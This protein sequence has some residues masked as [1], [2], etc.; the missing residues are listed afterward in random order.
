[1]MMQLYFHEF[2]LQLK[3]IFAI[4][5][6][7]RTVQP[8]LIVELKLKEISGFGEATAIKYYDQTTEKF[9]E[10]LLKIKAQIT[11]NK[12]V[13]PFEFYAQICSLT[14]NQFLRSALDCAYH[15]LY[16]KV[17]QIP[18]F[19]T[20]GFSNQAKA[21]SSYTIGVDDAAQMLNKI[22]QTPWPI[23]KIK[24]NTGFDIEILGFLKRHTSAEF[25]IDANT[26]FSYKHLSEVHDYLKDLSINIIEQPLPTNQNP[27]MLK[28]K[29]DFDFTFIADESFQSAED[30]EGCI[31]YF[32]C[33]NIKLLKCGGITSAFQIIE[34]VKQTPTKL[35]IGCMTQSSVAISAAA[36]LS[37]Q[38]NYLDLDGAMLLSNDPARGVK[39]LPKRLELDQSY[40]NAGLELLH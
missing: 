26:G 22:K 10:E 39:I 19:K 24:V 8:T 14:R 31:K 15:D 38:A 21:I 25:R 33:I 18:T 34:K 12:L 30:I 6:E 29:E 36:Q 23:Y 17:K 4:Q 27:E 16:G 2:E 7:K 5:H 40:G 37:A 32:D 13:H 35:M 20:L 9:K 11:F 1:M 3:D 28:F